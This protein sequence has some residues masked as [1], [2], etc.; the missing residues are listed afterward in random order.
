MYRVEYLVTVDDSTAFCKNVAGL[1]N[2]LRTIDG[3]KVSS[4]EIIAGD[5]KIDYEIEAG[6]ISNDRQRFFHL[7]FTLQDGDNLDGFE[8]ALRSVRAVLHRVGSRPPQVLWD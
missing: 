4:N 3:L 1:N 5:L 8:E 2:L 7:R 6:S